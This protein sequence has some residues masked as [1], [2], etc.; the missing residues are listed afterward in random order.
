ML[1]SLNRFD[2]AE[3]E[4]GEA[5]KLDPNLWQA[6]IQRGILYF[7]QKKYQKALDDFE[8]EISLNKQLNNNKDLKQVIA[9]CKKAL[10]K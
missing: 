9:D 7:M 2:E 3:K 6:Y 5:I 10:N 4:Y 1:K 8:Q